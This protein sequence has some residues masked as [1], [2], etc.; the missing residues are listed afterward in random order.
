MPPSR[1]APC[2]TAAAFVRPSSSA[3]ACSPPRSRPTA[4]APPRPVGTPPLLKVEAEG[5]GYRISIAG[6]P[7]ADIAF[8]TL[9][10]RVPDRIVV[11]TLDGET[12]RVSVGWTV[13]LETPQDELAVAFRWRLKPDFW[14]APHLAPEP[15]FVV[16]QHVFRSP[17]L[18]TARAARRWPSSPTSTWSGGRTETPGSWTT[19]RPRERPGLGMT[20]TDDPDPC[21]VQEE[22]G[23]D[24]RARERRDRLL[25]AGFARHRP[26]R[27]SL[28]AGGGLPVDALGPAACSNRASPSGPL[29][30]ATSSGPTPGPSDPG[31][32]PSGRSSSWAAAK[33]ARPSSSSTSRNRRTPPSPGISAN[34]F[35]SGTRPG[36]RRFA[37]PRGST[38]TGAGRATTS[39]LRKARLAKELALAAPQTDGLFP[40]V[41]RT[42]NDRGRS[43]R[44]EAPPAP[45][46]GTRPI[47][48][49]PTAG[50][51]NTASRPTGSTSST[52]AG[53][54]LQMLRWH[55]DLEPDPR[56]LD[57]ARSLRRGPAAAFRTRTGSSRAGSIPGPRPPGR[58]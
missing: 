6:T 23:P 15:G 35:P 32:R 38:A 39:I 21:P 5:A 24:V 7:W 18:I 10:G 26:G 40:S 53:R 41:I 2:P 49:I 43:R 44:Q 48:P 52:P 56:L 58:S 55:E 11:G 9:A 31:A 51:P 16:A 42:D 12:V 50:R 29:W 4:A 37:A 20:L 22:A 8:P 34:S 45:R 1:R 54:P 57:Y 25:R 14:W 36:S 47:G 13:L 17:A 3:P 19:T 46:A 33:S 30:T 27:R 28:A